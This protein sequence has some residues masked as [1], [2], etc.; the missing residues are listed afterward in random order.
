MEQRTPAE[1]VLVEFWLAL[2]SMLRSYGAAHG[3]GRNEQLIVE[4]DA[5][6]MQVRWAQ[7]WIEFRRHGAEVSLKRWDGGTESLLWTAEG[8][9]KSHAADDEMDMAAER[10]ARELIR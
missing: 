8:R 9:L 2:A 3:L 7:R 4:A 10:W 6:R 5:E 1:P